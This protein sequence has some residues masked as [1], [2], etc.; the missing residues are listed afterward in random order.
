MNGND[1]IEAIE[2]NIELIEGDFFDDFTKDE[3]IEFIIYNNYEIFKN[4]YGFDDF[5]ND[6]IADN[7]ITW[8]N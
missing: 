8:N 2:Q 4:E 6:W 1:Y 7:V 5:A 3:L